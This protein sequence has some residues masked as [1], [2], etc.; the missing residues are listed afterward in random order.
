MSGKRKSMARIVVIACVTALTAFASIALADGGGWEDGAHC[1]KHHQHDF[2]KIA[3]KLGLTDAQK[4][5]AKAIF[6]A[7]KEV[8]K[9]IVTNLRAERK[10]LRA[11]MHADTIDE[12]AIRAE[13]ARMAGIQADLN[14]NRAKVGA[15]FR[16]ILTPSQLAALK[17]LQQKHCQKD[18]ATTTPAE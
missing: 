10:N 5:Q 17:A 1:G 15:Q 12:A 16:A 13:T 6:Q 11:L 3:K 4:A 14:V 2:K 9:P 7:N 8:M 18:D